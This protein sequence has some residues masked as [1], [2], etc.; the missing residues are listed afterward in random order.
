MRN[1]SPTKAK[2]EEN[3]KRKYKRDYSYN[4]DKKNKDKEET[5]PSSFKIV[6]S[7]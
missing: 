5:N 1:S 2:G 7:N 6:Y 4:N 3:T